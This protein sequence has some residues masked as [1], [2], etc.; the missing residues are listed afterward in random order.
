MKSVLYG[1]LTDESGLLGSNS[2]DKLHP[3]VAIR[4]EETKNNAND[5]TGLVRKRPKAVEASDASETNGKRR[6]EDNEENKCK[7]AKVGNVDS[8]AANEK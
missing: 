7:K 2:L 6:A 8:E 3:A 1:K 4:V 5:V